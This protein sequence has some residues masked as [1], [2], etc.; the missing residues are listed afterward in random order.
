MATVTTCLHKYEA[1]DA[2]RRGYLDVPRD[3]P[4]GAAAVVGTPST[5]WPDHTRAPNGSIRDPFYESRITWCPVFV[6]DPD[7]GCEDIH[8]SDG[9]WVPLSNDCYW[10]CQM[11]DVIPVVRGDKPVERDVPSVGTNGCPNDRDWVPEPGH[12][13]LVD[14]GLYSVVRLPFDREAA[15]AERAAGRKVWQPD[16][17][18]AC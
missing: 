13:T 2:C 6:H 4:W 8:L 10:E 14:P 5:G 3:N 12:P 1:C 11:V 15:G 7:L 9:T 18:T 17:A 16:P